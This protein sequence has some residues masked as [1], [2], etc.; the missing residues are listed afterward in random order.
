MTLSHWRKGCRG[1]L[2]KKEGGRNSQFIFPIPLKSQELEIL[3]KKPYLGS[4]WSGSSGRVP[5]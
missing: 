1:F 3:D 2:K 4:W 5:A